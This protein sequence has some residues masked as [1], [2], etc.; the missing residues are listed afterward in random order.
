MVGA[1]RFS[2]ARGFI[3][4]YSA[5]ASGTGHFYKDIGDCRVVHV[6]VFAIPGIDIFPLIGIFSVEHYGTMRGL[7]IIA[8][9]SPGV[10]LVHVATCVAGRIRSTIG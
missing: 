10:V 2:F 9:A 1:G 5:A 6:A 7:S 3:D 8:D 4:V